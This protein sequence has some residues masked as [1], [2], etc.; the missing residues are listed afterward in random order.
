MMIRLRIG[1]WRDVDLHEL[2]T[3]CPRTLKISLSVMGECNTGRSA[4]LTHFM[5]VSSLRFR[6]AFT[7]GS[8]EKGPQQLVLSHNSFWSRVVPLCLLSQ[9]LITI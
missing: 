5:K 4:L 9:S 2:E 3:H 8:V 6:Q 7:E 1:F